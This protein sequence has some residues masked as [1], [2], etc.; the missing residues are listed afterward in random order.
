MPDVI[1]GDPLLELR[2]RRIYRV[3]DHNPAVWLIDDRELGGIL[4]T[5]SPA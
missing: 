5:S 1:L 3:G 4:L 2:D